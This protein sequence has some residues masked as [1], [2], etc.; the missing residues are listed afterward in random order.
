MKQVTPKES[1][2]LLLDVLADI[3]DDRPLTESKSLEGQQSCAGDIAVWVALAHPTLAENLDADT[4]FQG[5]ARLPLH[6]RRQLGPRLSQSVNEAGN[7][8][9]AAAILRA[10]DRAAQ[11]VEPEV[12][13]AEARIETKQGRQEDATTK[14][15]EVV[16]SG[17]EY[18]PEALIDLVE[19]HLKDQKPLRPDL[20]DLAIAYSEEYR[21]AESAPDLRRASAIALSLAGR[22]EEA[23]EN[24]K[25]LR[26]LD[27]EEA[28][29]SVK[30]PFFDL[31][32]RNAGDVE[33]LS[34]ALAE[35]ESSK[36]A[37]PPGLQTRMAERLL[38]LGFAE[39]AFAMLEQ[40]VASEHPEPRRILRAEAALQINLPHRAM[41][42]VMNLGGPDASDI[43]S[44]A[45]QMNGDFERAAQL[46]SETGQYEFAARSFW[47]GDAKAELPDDQDGGRY[48]HLAELS[49]LISANTD[50]EDAAPT[51]ATARRFLDDS[52]LTR[53]RIAELLASVPLEENTD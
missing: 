26:N 17:S 31:L 19:A 35:F 37:L 52:E 10:M 8:E 45:M 20:P 36:A 4:M 33:F 18:T 14:M 41:I 46:Q 9:L 47:L 39:Q 7:V 21:L 32:Q 1:G 42:E 11:H 16:D 27:G 53:Q 2:D 44:R 30:I 3:L 28:E 6:I 50:V 23:A 49:Q 51:L 15:L 13:L 24:I 34:Y 12:V 25:K 38:E 29:V 43:R 48:G 5:F 40:I 22:F